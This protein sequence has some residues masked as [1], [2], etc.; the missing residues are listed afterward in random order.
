MNRAAASIYLLI[1]LHAAFFTETPSFHV[2]FKS[3]FHYHPAS[4]N[5]MCG[6][7]EYRWSGYA[8]TSY[9]LQEADVAHLD[10]SPSS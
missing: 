2:F 1:K 9:D 4:I 8:N 3:V 5:E 10:A 7:T 6:D